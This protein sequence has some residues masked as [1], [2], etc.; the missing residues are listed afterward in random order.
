MS[1]VHRFSI[2]GLVRRV[3]G[4][5]AE[6]EQGLTRELL[7][8]HGGVCLWFGTAMAAM[9]LGLSPMSRHASP[10]ISKAAQEGSALGIV[11]VLTDLRFCTGSSLPTQTAAEEASTLQIFLGE[12]PNAVQRLRDNS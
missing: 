8:L 1:Q 3:S 5:A 11:T 12:V 10:F 2:S 7:C 4:G 9:T 6:A